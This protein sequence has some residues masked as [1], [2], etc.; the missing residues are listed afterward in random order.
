LKTKRDKQ[1]PE[2][3]WS[4]FFAILKNVRSFKYM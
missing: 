1:L 4:F 3:E 2:S